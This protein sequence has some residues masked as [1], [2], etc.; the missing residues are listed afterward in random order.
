MSYRHDLSREERY[1]VELVAVTKNDSAITIGREK[2]IINK[3]DRL[4]GESTWK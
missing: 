4:V 2:S 3:I 1:T